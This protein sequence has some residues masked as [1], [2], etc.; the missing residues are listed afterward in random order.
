MSNQWDPMP[1]LPVPWGEVFDKFTI[2]Q[3]KQVR[4]AEPAKLSNICSEIAVIQE[5]IGDTRRF[6]E[7]TTSLLNQLQQVNEAI[8]QVEDDKRQCE[9]E[10][11]FDEHFVQ[12]ARQVYQLNDERARL[13]KQIDQVLGST[14]T[15]EK[16][17][18]SVLIP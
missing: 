8:W 10:K 16:S 9:R 18:N 12:L 17:H 4:I 7:G 1:T 11:R 2:L 14:L 6:P 15:E 5:V 3:I 13:K